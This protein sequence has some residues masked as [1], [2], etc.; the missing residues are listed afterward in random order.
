MC[1][2]ND[3]HFRFVEKFDDDDIDDKSQSVSL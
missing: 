3:I 1:T 2:T